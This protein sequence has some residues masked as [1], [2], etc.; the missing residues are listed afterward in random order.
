[1][2]GWRDAF[3][4]VKPDTLIGWYPKGFRLFWHWKSRPKGRPRLP[5][6]L[7]QLIRE[8]A[9]RN[10][11]WGEE[12]IANELKLKFGIRVS[13]RTVGK[14]VRAGGPVRPRRRAL[15]RHR[16]PT[17]HTVRSAAVVGGLHHE[18]WLEK[19]AA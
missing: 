5:K 9:V 15:H 8:M 19:L 4:N 18:Y 7:W 3:W 12:W 2:F 13:P 17:G 6:E 16:I 1:M 14:Y 10:V 11:T